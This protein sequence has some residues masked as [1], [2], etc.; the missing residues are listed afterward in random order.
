MSTIETIRPAS[1]QNAIDSGINVFFIQNRFSVGRSNKNAIPAFGARCLRRIKP[2]LRAS[3]VSAISTRSDTGPSAESNRR[4]AVG[5]DVRGDEGL[6]PGKPG[7]TVARS[8]PHETATAT[9]TTV[10]IPV[11]SR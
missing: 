7:R 2:T 11:W 9:T 8:E 4:V 1:S 3:G 5:G 10:A 6:V